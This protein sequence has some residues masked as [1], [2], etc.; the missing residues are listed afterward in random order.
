MHEAAIAQSIVRTVLQEAEKQGAIKVESIEVEI[1]ELTF[2]GIDQ[3]KFWVE[4]SF[5]ETIAD[6]AEL[7]FKNIKAQI[8]CNDCGYEGHLTV[9]EDPA[10]HISLPSFSCP[11]CKSTRIEITQGK[12]AFIRQIK[13]LKE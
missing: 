2:L 7:I 13:I 1:G 8:R 12:E 6:G 10:Y 11:R 9:K 3:V 5:Q 4:T